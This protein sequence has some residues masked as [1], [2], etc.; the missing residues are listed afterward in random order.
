MSWSPDGRHIAYVSERWDGKADCYVVDLRTGERRLLT[1]RSSKRFVYSGFGPLWDARGDAVFLPTDHAVWQLH[2]ATGNAQNLVNV[3]DRIVDIVSARHGQLAWSPRPGTLLLIVRDTATKRAALVHVGVAR[4]TVTAG[5]DIPAFF[6]AGANHAIG[7]E[8]A[9]VALFAR[10]DASHPTDVWIA[11]GAATSMRRLTRLNPSFDQFELGQARLV[12][13]KRRDGSTAAATVL[14]PANYVAGRK[15]PTI[16]W[17]YPSSRG[18]DYVFQFGLWTIPYNMQLLATRGYA[19][20]Y[21]D[22][23]VRFGT[24]MHDIADEVGRA[25]DGLA[26]LGIADTTR[27]GVMGHSYG[28]YGVYS[29]IVQT[30]RFK[31]AVLSSGLIDLT[32]MYGVMREDGVAGGVQHLETGQGRIGAPP[33]GAPELY[34]DNSP[35]YFL[36]RVQTPM[37]IEA[38]LED[39]N[40][41]A[42]QADEAFVGLRRLGKEVTLIKYRGEEHVL[43]SYTNVT[44]FWERTLAFFGRKLK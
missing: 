19:V 18:S 28:G 10:Q 25:V 33:W 29:V 14:L 26:Q 15:Y 41:P 23:Q 39:P 27:L 36:D 43:K 9:S 1:G 30:S 12:H 7:A 24:P 37:L 34:V 8:S 20:L 42:A 4:G 22:C 31:A 35:I 13:W 44:D 3:D 21:P 6:G 2:I 11:T 16:V 5:E 32:A 40:V 38:G 17:L